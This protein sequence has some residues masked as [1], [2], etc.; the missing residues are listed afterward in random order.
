MTTTTTLSP[1]LD[2]VLA[3]VERIR[4]VLE[5]HAAQ[6]E[7]ERHLSDAYYD[8]MIGAGL[9]RL[10]VPHAFGGYQFAPVDAYRVWEAVSRIDSSYPP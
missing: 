5:Q 4:V 9:F 6:A 3:A 10:L 8:A 7:S 1:T 2:E